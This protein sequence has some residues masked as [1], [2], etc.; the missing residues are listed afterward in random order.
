VAE[1]LHI[2]LMMPDRRP[3]GRR[4]RVLS[5]AA[6]HSASRDIDETYVY[7]CGTTKSLALAFIR[8]QPKFGHSANVD[9]SEGDTC[10]MRFVRIGTRLTFVL[11]LALT[12]VLVAYTYWSMQRSTRTYVNDL[13][14]ETRAIT[15][16]LTPALENDIRK[17]EWDE[18]KDIFRRIG[19]DGTAIALFGGDGTTWYALRDFPPDLVPARES[20]FHTLKD[21]S[22]MSGRPGAA[23]GFAG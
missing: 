23:P 8:K 13:K 3:I 15:R 7:Q 18:V 1:Q 21:L 10:I 4:L 20:S 16:G 14:R 12:P 2:P 22:N 11:L 9:A 6:N 19:A 5:G 17:N